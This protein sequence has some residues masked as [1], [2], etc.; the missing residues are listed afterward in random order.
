[1]KQNQHRN[2]SPFYQSSP[3][4]REQAICTTTNC[5]NFYQQPNF[6]NLTMSSDNFFNYENSAKGIYPKGISRNT[7]MTSG[8]DDSTTTS[9]SYV[10]DDDDEYVDMVRPSR[11]CIV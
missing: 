9:G 3:R 2:F 1:M 11:Q 4:G 7:S 10:I 5:S 8:H 6:K